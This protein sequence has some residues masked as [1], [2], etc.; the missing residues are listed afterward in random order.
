MSYNKIPVKKCA[1]TCARTVCRKSEQLA[2][3]VLDVAFGVEAS[4]G[5]QGDNHVSK[6]AVRWHARVVGRLPKTK[7]TQSVLNGHDDHVA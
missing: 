6:T 5:P 2:F 3:T 4:G 7:E 1:N